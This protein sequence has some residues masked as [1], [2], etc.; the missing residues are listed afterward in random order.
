M[1]ATICRP[2]LP[3]NGGKMVPSVAS[4]TNFGLPDRRAQVPEQDRP[5]AFVARA[6][7]TGALV[8]VIVRDSGQRLS[9]LLS[10]RPISHVA[11][12]APNWGDGWMLVGLLDGSSRIVGGN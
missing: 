3:P 4:E 11:V 5:D 9:G 12:S 2:P 6:L 7:N 10:L 8:P 1:V